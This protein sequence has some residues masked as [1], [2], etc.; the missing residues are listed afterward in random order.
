MDT[1]STR[2][3]DAEPG[4]GN[5]PIAG[6]LAEIRESLRAAFPRAKS[7]LLEFDGT[8][9]AHIDVREGELVPAIEAQLA[10]IDNGRFTRVE[11][12]ATPHHPFLHRISAVISA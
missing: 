3:Q 12:G 6:Q 8:F 5:Q 11:H 1:G 9:K 4:P 2:P 7:V 10:H